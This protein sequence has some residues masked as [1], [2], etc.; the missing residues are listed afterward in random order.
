MGIKYTPKINHIRFSLVH[1][2]ELQIPLNHAG[3]YKLHTVKICTLPTQSPTHSL[4]H[5]HKR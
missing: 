3:A 2:A 4:G 5:S 1:R